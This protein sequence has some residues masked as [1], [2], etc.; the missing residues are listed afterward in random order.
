MLCIAKPEI[1]VLVGN[2][3]R[4]LTDVRSTWPLIFSFTD[5][6]SS[7]RRSTITQVLTI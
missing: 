2:Y 6:S 3:D 4:D 5:V 7:M 1:L